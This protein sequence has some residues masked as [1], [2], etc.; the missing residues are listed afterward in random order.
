MHSQNMD[1]VKIGFHN[2]ILDD[3]LILFGFVD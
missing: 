2:K 3:F 1:I